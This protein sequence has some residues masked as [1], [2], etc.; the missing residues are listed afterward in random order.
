MWLSSSKKMRARGAS[1]RDATR[2]EMKALR[3]RSESLR[4]VQIRR[5]G[6]SRAESRW[7]AA[8]HRATESTG[9]GRGFRL[10][11]QYYA[12]VGGLAKAAIT[13]TISSLSTM[14][15]SLTGESLPSRAGSFNSQPVTAM[16]GYLLDFLLV[17]R[18]GPSRPSRLCL[19]IRL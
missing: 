19:P 10:P 5:I 13:T 9:N 15:G 8:G 4:V 7:K 3:P 12:A 1:D 2:Y 17:G 14:A 18:L 11:R 6:Q 16:L